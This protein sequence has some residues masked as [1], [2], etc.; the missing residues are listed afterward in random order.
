MWKKDIIQQSRK[1][2]DN[3]QVIH[4]KDQFVS[5]YLLDHY[6]LSTTKLNHYKFCFLYKQLSATKYQKGIAKVVD[7][8][9]DNW[10]EEA[11]NG[12]ISIFK[13]PHENEEVVASKKVNT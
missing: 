2:V 5:V 1:I 6:F 3:E 12:E 4:R 8:E 10:T 11:I 9:I 7:A 13:R